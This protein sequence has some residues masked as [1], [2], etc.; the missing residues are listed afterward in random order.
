MANRD[1]DGYPDKECQQ[2]KTPRL[3]TLQDSTCKAE[4]SR[5][6]R[7][8]RI[9]DYEGDA[10]ELACRRSGNGETALKAYRPRY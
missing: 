3:G 2:C 1:Q 8:E 10:C 5:R 7:R 9:L 6:N 4:R